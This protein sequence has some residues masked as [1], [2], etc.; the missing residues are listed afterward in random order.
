VATLRR[1]P[2]KQRPE[3]D[4]ELRAAIADDVDARFE[5]GDKPTDAEFAALKEMGDPYRLAASCTNRL[6]TLIG[7]DFYPTFVRMLRVVCI[8]V[9]PVLYVTLAAVSFAQGNNPW[10]SVFGPLGSTISVGIYIAFAITVMFAIA[11]RA[12][13]SHPE[14][15]KSDL[16][17]TPNSLAAEVETPSFT[18][19]SDVL[20]QLVGSVVVVV[21]L[22]ADRFTPVVTGK[23]S[24][25]A[26]LDPTLWHFWI[27]AFIVLLALAVVLERVKQRVGHRRLGTAIADGVLG[28][29]GAAGLIVVVLTTTV[30]NPALTSVDGLAPGSWIWMIV[31]A[32]I[33]LIWIV[34]TLRTWLPGTHE[35]PRG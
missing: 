7:P 17:W 28:L 15:D 34:A 18:K 16:E 2:E 32:A 22:L 29:I 19:W 31:A 14:A 20:T 35:P 27:P 4:K 3:I 24:H 30:L 21:L 25:V 8:I 26:I 11:E 10:G 6:L 12:S 13:A 5:D 9:L 23:H 1:V 33:A